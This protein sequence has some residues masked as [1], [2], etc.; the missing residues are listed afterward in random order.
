MRTVVLTSAQSVSMVNRAE[1][2]ARPMST[3]VAIQSAPIIGE[4]AENFARATDAIDDA[5]S[6]GADVVVLPELVTS[7]YVFESAAE[8]RSLAVA[9]THSS[10]A[11]WARAAS[12]RPG[13]LVVAGFAELGDDGQV[14]NSAAMVDSTGIVAV[15]RKVHL[16]DAEKLFFTPGEA[17]P[18]VVETVHGNVGVVV[19]YDLEFPE[20][21]RIVALKGADLL[22]VPTNWPLVPRPAS[23][24]APEIVIALATA[25]MNRLPIAVAD[26]VGT[27]RGVEW[28]G[29]TGLI[30][31]DGW[32]VDSAGAGVGTARAELDLVASRDK[33]AALNADLHGDRRPELYRRLAAPLAE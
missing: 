28:T 26:R 9:P 1:G 14:Y 32:I 21:S 2:K 18:P 12:R 20:W 27:E 15:Y 16:W 3:I 24:R 19:C 17:E 22:A 5:F 11:G 29:G 4:L 13:G 23:E 33:A 25:R 6:D 7:G 31:A 8:A 30:G 10:F